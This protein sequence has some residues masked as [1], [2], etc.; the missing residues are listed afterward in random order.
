MTVWVWRAPAL[1]C[2][3]VSI[4]ETH[5]PPDDVWNTRYYEFGYFGVMVA[6]SEL[7]LE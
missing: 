4:H 5:P 1:R 2:R 3:R 6:W 7:G